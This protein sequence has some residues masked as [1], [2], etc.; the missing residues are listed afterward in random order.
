MKVFFDSGVFL[1]YLAGVGNAKRLMDRVER[2]EWKGYVN[3]IV[4]S[5]GCLRVPKI[6]SQ[7]FSI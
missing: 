4:I 5:E 2:G 7:C 1:K 6:S 3:D